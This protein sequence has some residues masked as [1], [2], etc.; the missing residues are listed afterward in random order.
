MRKIKLDLI[1]VE[2]ILTREQLKHV[3]GGAGSFGQP[4]SDDM[5]CWIATQGSSYCNRGV[6]TPYMGEGSSTEGCWDRPMT[7]QCHGSTLGCCPSPVQTCTNTVGGY[8]CI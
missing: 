4:C 7:Q 5:T 3:V 1:K 8:I 2:E 6:C